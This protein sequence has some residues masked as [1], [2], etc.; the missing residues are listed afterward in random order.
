MMSLGGPIAV[1]RT[2]E[3]YAWEEGQVL[4]LFHG[5]VQPDS[6]G[7]EARIARA[8]H[9]AGL[10]VPA[11][12]E[13]VKIDGRLGLIYER[14]DGASM[15]ETL[16]AKPWMLPRFGRLL[17]EWH[18]DVHASSITPELPSQ[19]QRLENK[20]RAAEA[21]PPDLKEA[22]L[23]ALDRMPD[24]DRLCHGDFMPANVMIT[25]R[26][27]VVIDWTD[28]TRGNPLA[29][30]ARSSVIILGVTAPTP[31][32]PWLVKAAIRWYHRMYL[33]RYFQL[34]PGGREEW[35]AWKPI[36][37]AARLSESIPEIQEWLLGQV[38]AG[39]SQRD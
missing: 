7:Y 12:G 33:N 16:T 8:V 30:V 18:A 6:V 32:V 38:K 23:R 36:V 19:R 15:S 24:G 35:R 5:W 14:V 27:P 2:A 1:G 37:A 3:I 9:A 28:A 29:D 21:L 25:A 34:R 17:A 11:V 39:L 13:I 22:T 4:K 26:G 20:I 10:P 31:S